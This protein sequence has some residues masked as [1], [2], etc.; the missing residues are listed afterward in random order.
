MRIWIGTLA[1]GLC[2]TQMLNAQVVDDFTSKPAMNIYKAQERGCDYAVIASPTDSNKLVGQFGW[3][4]THAGFLE[5]YY[6]KDLAIPNTTQSRD[7]KLTLSLYT[8]QP[9]SIK[10]LALR[11]K[12]ASGEIHHY[13]VPLSLKANTWND[14]VFDLIQL[15][16]LGHWG[17]NNDGKL[18]LPL[19]L[20][21]YAWVIN[22]TAIAGQVLLGNVT[23]QSNAVTAEKTPTTSP[24]DHYPLS[25]AHLSE[26][27]WSSP[28]MYD[29]QVA[30]V[31]ESS[32]TPADGTLLFAPTKVLS[33]TSS[34]GKTVYEQG[35][36]YTIDAANKR[37]ILTPASRIPSIKR[38]ELFKKPNEKKAI[39]NKV[40]DPETWLLYA[41]T[42]FPAFR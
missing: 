27:A 5:Y 41:E 26:P 7:G 18:D 15:Q 36:D 32:D 1:F 30:M 40:D 42:G 34:V 2:L 14:V 39:K 8:A 21:G 12:D 29:E 3:Q 25:K 19:K 35:K 31:Q 17:G 28:V 33:I 38:D 11:I 6:A 24:M 9:S 37:I 23:W 13:Q 22:K 10:G 20:T 16:V 4:D